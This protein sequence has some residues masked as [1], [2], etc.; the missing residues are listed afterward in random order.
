MMP[1]K[2]S[3]AEQQAPET[4]ISSEEKA[5]PRFGPSPAELDALRA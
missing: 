5:L 2:D 3:S 1:E 4:E